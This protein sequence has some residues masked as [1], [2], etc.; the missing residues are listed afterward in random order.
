MPSVT[1]V[2]PTF[3]EVENIAS[4]IERV[5]R[6]L[7]AVPFDIVVVD[8]ST[9][10]TDQL[11]ARMAN[12]DPRIRLIHRHGR[13]G[14]ASAVVEG[15]AAAPGDLVCVLDAD[16]QHPPEV[17]PALVDAL[18]RSGA[19]V[20]VASRHLAGSRD[21]GLS[22]VR[23]LVSRAASVL[24][25]VL[26]PRARLSSD[27]LSGCFAFRRPVVEGVALRP[28]GY[29]I[30]LEVLVRGRLHQVAEV[31]YR[32]D[33]RRT[34]QSKLTMRQNWEYLQHLWRLVGAR[35]YERRD[36]RQAIE[37]ARAAVEGRRLF[38]RHPR[39]GP[40]PRVHVISSNGDAALPRVSVIIP[41]ADAT[42]SH[43]LDRLVKQLWDQPFRSLEVITVQGDRRQ[44]RAVNT[45]AAIARGSLLITMDDDTRLSDPYLIQK[46]V[47]VFDADPT[48][49][50][51]GVSNQVPDDAPRIVRRAMAQL[52]R[53]SSALVQTVTDSD[54]AEH[55]CLAI[56]TD[57]FRRIG[58]ELEVMPRGLDPYLR[59]EVRRLGYRVV[60]IPDTWIHHLLPPTGWGILRQYFRN[61]MGAAYAQKFHPEFVIEQAVSHNQPVRTHTS[62]PGRALRYLGRT[63]QAVFSARWIYLG[64][65]V[66]YAAGYAW[67]WC[68]LREDG[69]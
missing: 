55:P 10:G 34:G 7:A 31:P 50:I 52:P 19:D 30:L 24:A 45:A 59:G 57:L 58:G 15:I 22:P 5:S 54:L 32:F 44:G 27:P 40:I 9:D 37:L 67:G 23:R 53:R 14:L 13:R 60:V 3:N 20:A 39:A 49:G 26:L 69:S 21:D 48:I 62:L 42:R 66:T 17:L 61:G 16:L 18:D 28:I 1:A 29:K 43:H 2:L 63:A 41:S 12:A 4:V 56:P 36:D 38:V 11:V 8:D 47:A 6:A 25:R 33:T 64:T 35:R 68:V 65:L 51:A 46:L